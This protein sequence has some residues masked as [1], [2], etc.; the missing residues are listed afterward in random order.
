MQLPYLQLLIF[1][2]LL[3]ST[4]LSEA[5]LQL[6]NSGLP[7]MQAAFYAVK[8]PYMQCCSAAAQL[9]A[10]F[11]ALPALQHEVLFFMLLPFMLICFC[12]F[13]QG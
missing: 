4:A 1:G 7:F 5:A 6:L 3:H 10:A 9:W 2:C 11:Y 12:E 8:L 13:I